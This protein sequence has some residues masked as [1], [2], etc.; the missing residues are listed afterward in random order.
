MYWKISFTVSAEKEFGK[1]SKSLQQQLVRY[2]E[3]II[4]DNPRLHGKALKGG[5]VIKLWRYRVDKYRIICQIQ[6]SELL[7][8]VVRIA[9]RDVVYK[10]L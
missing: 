3:R 2:F 4:I 5:S 6:D 10:D 1:L 7:I 8:L 9:K